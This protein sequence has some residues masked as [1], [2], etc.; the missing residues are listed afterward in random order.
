ME[1]LHQIFQTN[2]G[3]ELCVLAGY[4][5]LI[6]HLTESRITWVKALW[7]CLQG[8]SLASWM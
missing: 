7:M 4:S 1:I 6:V 3:S 8:I 5:V 2:S